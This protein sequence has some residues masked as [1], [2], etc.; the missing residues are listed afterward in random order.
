[1]A[2]RVDPSSTSRLVIYDCFTFFNELD[3]LE[4][5]LHVLSPIVDRFVLVEAQETH[6]GDAK[7]LLFQANRARFRPFLDRIIHIPIGRFPQRL[8][9]A[10]DRERFQRE[11]IQCGLSHATFGDLILIS[12]VDEIPHPD[13]IARPRAL[14]TIT[15]CR[16]HLFYYF[17][18]CLA[19]R[20]NGRTG[21]AAKEGN[22]VIYTHHS[23][24]GRPQDYRDLIGLRGWRGDTAMHRARA[25]IRAIRRRNDLVGHVRFADDGGWH[26]SYLGGIDAVIRK[27]EAY[28]HTEYNL[29]TYKD[30]ERIRA[31]MQ[32]G[33]D[34]FGRDLGFEFIAFDD[35]HPPWLRANLDRYQH[36][37]GP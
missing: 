18:N 3:V 26:F 32:A 12:D 20:R 33:S 36:L 16:Q 23:G 2:H 1:L 21:A 25:A 35:R 19:I 17:L 22:T 14:D 10:W 24:S 29:A 5:R 27:L 13:T 6:Q 28:A 11:Q 9:T 4:I 31:S 34:L 8:R 37:I 15:V 30:R 7:A